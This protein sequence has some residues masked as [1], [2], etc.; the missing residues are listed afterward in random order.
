MVSS[1]TVT[2]NMVV[3]R[4]Q[5]FTSRIRNLSITI[6]QFGTDKD[7]KTLRDQVLQN[8]HAAHD[9]SKQI[10]RDL[11]SLNSQPSTDRRVIMKLKLTF[12]QDLILLRQCQEDIEHAEKRSLRQQPTATDIR[13]DSDPLRQPSEKNV[14]EQ[15][16]FTNDFKE[17]ALDEAIEKKEKLLQIETDVNDIHEMFDDLKLL[18]DEQQ[19]HLDTVENNIQQVKTHTVAATKNVEKA[20]A[21]QRNTRKCKCTSCVMLLIAIVILLVLLGYLKVF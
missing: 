13:N 10:M 21:I 2:E 3:D 6:D 16:E 9:L 11:K 12:E 20:A 15:V 4:L 19:D 5:D 1:M 18:V 14:M 8:S 7:T 17:Y